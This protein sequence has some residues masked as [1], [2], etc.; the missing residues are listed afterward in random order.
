MKQPKR[1]KPLQQEGIPAGGVTLEKGLLVADIMPGG[2]AAGVA[3][4]AAAAAAAAGAAGPGENAGR[5][6]DDANTTDANNIAAAAAAAAAATTTNT[7][8]SHLSEK[9]DTA[10]VPQ[11]A[12]VRISALPPLTLDDAVVPSGIP[13]AYPIPGH[14]PAEY[15]DPLHVM[16]E[17]YVD[18]EERPSVRAS[19]STDIE[20][21]DDDDDDQQPQ[22]QS[23]PTTTNIVS[24]YRVADEVPAI[25]AIPFK[26]HKFRCFIYGI[27]VAVA[28]ITLIVGLSVGLIDKNNQDLPISS[29]INN[30]LGRLVSSLLIAVTVDEQGAFPVLVPGMFVKAIRSIRT[31]TGN[32]VATTTGSAV[33]NYCEVIPCIEGGCDLIRKV[34]E[35]GC[36]LGD[37]CN[38][39]SNKCGR[40]C[41]RRT[42]LCYPSFEGCIEASC[43]EC[44]RGPNGEELYRYRSASYNMNCLRTGVATGFNDKDDNVERTYKWAIVCGFNVQ[45]GN[46]RHNYAPG[47]YM[48]AAVRTGGGITKSVSQLVPCQVIQLLECGCA[49]ADMNTFGLPRPENPCQTKDDCPYLCGDA[50]EEQAKKLCEVFPG[51]EWWEG[52]NPTHQSLFYAPEDDLFGNVTIEIEIYEE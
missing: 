33:D 48:C 45:G 4:A 1:K 15:I 34:Y 28:V 50:G 51:I 11:T 9:Q 47:E 24:A 6:D 2:P 12:L 16:V 39:S 49:P 3:A 21:N 7:G 44:E 20:C 27:L 35:P 10:A 18:E 8:E 38:D 14:P 13:G 30:P 25:I 23:A 17:E 29:N 32:E 22:Q 43:F 31:E 37:D 36:C 40:I 26:D 41:P 52:G 19:A 42:D 46:E 5:G